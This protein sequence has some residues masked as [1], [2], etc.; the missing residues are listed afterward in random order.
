MYCRELDWMGAK[1]MTEVKISVIAAMRFVDD[2]SSTMVEY[3][4]ALDSLALNVVGLS[5]W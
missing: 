1:A 3:R 4:L 2:C 5:M